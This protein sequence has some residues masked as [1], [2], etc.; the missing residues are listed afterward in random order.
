MIFGEISCRNCI[1][2]FSVGKCLENE[3]KLTFTVSKFNEFPK[4]DIDKIRVS[5]SLVIF[6]AMFRAIEYSATC[7]NASSILFSFRAALMRPSKNRDL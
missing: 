2:C 7:S 6:L 3:A 1:N 4:S 5:F